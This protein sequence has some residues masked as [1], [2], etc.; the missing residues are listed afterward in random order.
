[1]LSEAFAPGRSRYS[2]HVEH[3]DV[4]FVIGGARN[5]FIDGGIAMEFPLFCNES[6]SGRLVSTEIKRFIDFVFCIRISTWARTIVG[7]KTVVS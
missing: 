3:T 1:L 4:E 2:K 7:L 5:S 6:V